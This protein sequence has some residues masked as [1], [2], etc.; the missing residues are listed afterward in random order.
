VLWIH[1]GF[2]EDFDMVPDPSLFLNADKDLD[3]R[4]QTNGDPC[5]PDPGTGQTLKPQK[6]EIHEIYIYCM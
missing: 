4:S 3:P 5:D 2:N 1:I 6:V